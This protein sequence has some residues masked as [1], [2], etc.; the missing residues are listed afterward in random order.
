MEK[1]GQVQQLFVYIF[2]LVVAAMIIGFGYYVITNIL[3]LGKEVETAT[4]KKDLE[5]QIGL[6]YTYAPNTNGNIQIRTPSGIKGICFINEGEVSDISYSDVKES[7]KI[8][9]SKN[10]FFSTTKEG[11]NAK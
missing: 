3:N 5:K 1:R 10:V 11:A 7:A 6:F 9:R 4:F 2:A 8:S